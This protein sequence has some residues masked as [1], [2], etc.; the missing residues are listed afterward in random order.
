MKKKILFSFLLI[1]VCFIFS[2]P[3]FAAN[4]VASVDG[5]SYTSFQ[6]A[7][8]SMKSGQTLT[9][10]TNIKTDKTV[11]IKGGNKELNINFASNKYSYTGNACAFKISSGNI[12]IRG[13]KLSSNNYVFKIMKGASLTI[14]NGSSSGYIDNRGTLIIKN[15][16]FNT[17]GAKESDNDELIYNHNKLTIDKGTFTATTDNAV[18]SDAGETIVNGGTFK[19]SATDDSTF[20]ATVNNAK[21]SILT[22]YA[23]TFTGIGPSICNNGKKTIIN[24]GN[25]CSSEYPS[26]VNQATTYINGGR[27]RNDTKEG[28]AAYNDKGTLIINDGSFENAV[29]NETK[30][31]KYLLIND[32]TFRSPTN[33]INIGNYG[34]TLRIKNGDFLSK[35]GNAIYNENGH[36]KISGGYFKSTKGYYALWNEDKATLTGGTFYTTGGNGKDIGC[37]TGATITVSQNVDG[38]VDYKN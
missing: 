7:V 33:I 5:K 17:N 38:Q 20:Y 12:V 9:V 24:G 36:V 26:I 14:Q 30:G 25:Y 31:K 6:K 32:G 37:K 11:T 2:T 8:D 27:I 13:M 3:S 16:S 15:G 34:G 10:L 21:E 4:Y 22:I 29:G 18:C 1:L 19:G 35:K 23:G 28:F